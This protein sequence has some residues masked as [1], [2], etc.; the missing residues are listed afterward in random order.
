MEKLV[1]HQHT[2]SLHFIQRVPF[3]YVVARYKRFV[4]VL[5][6]CHR[7]KDGQPYDTETA[8]TENR[9]ASEAYQEL[10]MMSRAGPVYNQLQ[11]S[12]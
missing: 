12:A 6:L 1:C 9:G 7:P 5:A 11:H 2:V 4:H 8:A 10:N 3:C